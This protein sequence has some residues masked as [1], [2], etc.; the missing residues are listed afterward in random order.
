MKP[1]LSIFSFGLRPGL[2]KIVNL[3]PCL[4]LAGT[5][6]RANRLKVIKQVLVF[7]EMAVF[8]GKKAAV[9]TVLK[10][11]SG[12]WQKKKWKTDADKSRQ[13]GKIQ[14]KKKCVD[15]KIDVAS[16][17]FLN[18]FMNLVCLDQLEEQ[19]TFY[20][21]GRDFVF[22]QQPT[23]SQEHIFVNQ[24]CSFL[25]LL[26]SQSFGSIQCIPNLSSNFACFFF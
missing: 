8:G 4:P 17:H 12:I 7:R 2:F 26:G 25:Q 23:E 19:F 24:L 6:I 10:L 13:K 18:T 11:Q 5:K 22:S 16:T 20:F 14:A 9:I 21:F 15:N 3:P 1:V